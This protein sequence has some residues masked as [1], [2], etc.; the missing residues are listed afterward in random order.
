MG[1][2][3]KSEFISDDFGIQNFWA[4]HGKISPRTRF[5]PK[6]TVCPEFPIQQTGRVPTVITRTSLTGPS[7]GLESCTLK[8]Y[9]G[10]QKFWLVPDPKVKFRS[11]TILSRN[12]IQQ[13]SWFSKFRNF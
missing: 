1:I 10:H 11:A 7:E 13:R 3:Q 4:A 5:T 12:K 8:W 2:Q 6:G 9:S